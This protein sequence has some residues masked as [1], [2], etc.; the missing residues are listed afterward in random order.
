ME[1]K[2]RAIENMR[3]HYYYIIDDYTANVRA[4]IPWEINSWIKFR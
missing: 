2:V 1:Q 4:K 3:K